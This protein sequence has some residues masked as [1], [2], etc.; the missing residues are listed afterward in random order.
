MAAGYYYSQL[1]S[2]LQLAWFFGTDH[3]ENTKFP[4]LTIVACVFVAA[5]TSLPSRCPETVA[6]TESPLSSM[7]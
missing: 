7:F 4:I 3:I 5:E 6:A 1:N 2:L